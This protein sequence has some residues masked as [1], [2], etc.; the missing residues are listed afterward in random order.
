[1]KNKGKFSEDHLD[2]LILRYREDELTD[3]EGQALG[4]LLSDFPE[5]RRRF[6]EQAFLISALE[7]ELKGEARFN[8]TKAASLIPFRKS[9]GRLRAAIGVAAA[10]VVGCVFLWLRPGSDPD[11]Y[12]V[13]HHQQERLDRGVAVLMEAL[14]VAWE[15]EA[16]EV[17]EIIEPGSLK[18]KSGV[19]QLEFYSGAS[20]VMEGEVDLEIVSAEHCILHHGGL[21]AVVP[22]QARGFRIESEEVTLIDLGTEFGMRVDREKNTQVHVFDGLVRLEDGI[23]PEAVPIDREVTEGQALRVSSGGGLEEIA[24]DQESFLT[25]DRLA[26]R[27]RDRGGKT[28]RRWEAFSKQLQRDAGLVAYFPFDQSDSE[29]R[30]LSGLI[31]EES[32]SGAI[33]GSEWR[34]GRWKHKSSLKFRRPSDRVRIQ[35]PGSFPSLTLLAWIRIDGLENDCNSI[36]M[37]NGWFGEGQVHWQIRSSGELAFAVFAPKDMGAQTM[38]RSTPVFSP[39][40][41][42][43][44]RH[45]AVTYDA[46]AMQVSHFL[47]GDLVGRSE[48]TQ[49]LALRFEGAE[50]GNWDVGDDHPFGARPV[51]NLQGSIDELAVLGRSLTPLEIAEWFRMGNPE[52]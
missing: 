37:S 1:M 7:D 24:M 40:D 12:E 19:V 18:L 20:L 34:N 9:H 47:D 25:I 26:E 51:R 13:A 29:S 27:V 11:A 33:V 6:S 41:H 17:G 31:L 16:M 21:R 3:R 39:A 44:W 42:G 48:I 5:A 22:L 4:T 38:W 2:H 8:A 46:E 30:L 23:G 32:Q 50:I 43:Q 36:L 15:G 49:A 14:D 45:V 28:F 10:L 52:K 35:I